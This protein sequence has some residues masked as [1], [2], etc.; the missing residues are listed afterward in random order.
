MKHYIIPIFIPHYGCI[1]SCVFCNQRKITGRDNPVRFQEV[2]TIIDEHLARIT[3]KRYIEV[4]FYGGSFTALPLKMQSELLEP[5]HKALTDG[6]I[7]N[8]RLSTRPDCITREIVDNLIKYGVSTIELGVQSLDN[9]VLEASARGHH[10]QDVF[11]A[12]SIIKKMNLRCG[13]QLM[14]GLP[15]EDWQSLIHTAYDVIKL[16]PDFVR[17]YPT[18]VIA[19]TKLAKMYQEGH[20]EALSLTAGVVRGAFLKLLFAHYEISTIRTGLQATEE[21]DKGNI[22]LGGPY[23]P[24]F[25][26]MVDSYIFYIMLVHCVESILLSHQTDDIIIHHHSRDTSKIRGIY[27]ENI[28]KIKNL[29]GIE[30]L[31]LIPDG[32]TKDEL[33]VEYKNLSYVINKKML[34]Y[35]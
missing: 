11:Q 27:N 32:F 13:L 31:I 7:H 1:H 14:P 2:A 29:Y 30:T 9:K 10:S 34:F 23:H 25:G 4:A 3:E 21:L 22:V 15:L 16:A 18:L 6:K 26:E 17:I 28:K 20:Y 24:A 19:N 5:A 35:I 33:L 8:I 12:I